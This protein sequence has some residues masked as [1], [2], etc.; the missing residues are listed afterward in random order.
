MIQVHVIP[1]FTDNYIWL[2]QFDNDQAVVIDPGN[3]ELVIE[4]LQ[5]RQLNLAAICIT[6]HHWDH[7]DGITTLLEQQ[8]VP[9]YGPSQ[10]TIPGLTH[11]SHEGDIIQFGEL[12]LTVFE[13]PGHTG[14]HLAY[15]GHQTLFSGDTLFAVGCGR[16]MGGS[17]KQLHDSLQRFASLPENT[18]VY[19]AHEYTL[20]NLKFALAVEPNNPDLILRQKD[21]QYK[22]QQGQPTLPSSLALELATNPFL[23]CREASVIEAVQKFSKQAITTEDDIFRALRY[24][25]DGFT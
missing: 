18:Q 19:C 14:S 12:Q 25:R 24:W 15:H 20:A 1:S 7:V 10:D 8:A 21:E 17:A 22:R 23:R 16:L 9:V 3:G 11:P 5:A 2:I 13:V 6:H 4:A